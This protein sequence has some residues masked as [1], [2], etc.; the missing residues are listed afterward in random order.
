[1][2]GKAADYSN[3]LPFSTEWNQAN[4]QTQRIGS[5]YRVVILFCRQQDGPKRMS[6]VCNFAQIPIF[7]IIEYIFIVDVTIIWLL[8][9]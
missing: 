4:E 8:L 5:G 7:K 9:L 1:M 6:Q 2:R 3:F